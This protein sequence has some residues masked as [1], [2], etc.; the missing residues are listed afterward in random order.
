MD[1]DILVSVIILNY[2]GEKVIRKTVDS[3]IRSNFPK[4]KFEIIIV[5]NASK[6]KSLSII[7]KIK[8]KYKNFCI[9]TIYSSINLGFAGGN[10]LGI[11]IALGKYIALLNND[12]IVDKNWL[13]ELY[14]AAEK[15]EKVFAVG[16]K[17]NLYPRY[18]NLKLNRENIQY[19]KK[20][21]LTK[22]NLIT[23]TNDKSI[24]L[25]YFLKKD[26]EIEVPFDY[27]SD[28]YIELVIYYH[29]KIKNNL[30]RIINKSDQN[31]IISR[32]WKK[33]IVKIKLSENLKKNS[34]SKIQNFGNLIFQDGYGRDIGSIVRYHTQYYENDLNQYNKEVER[35][36]AC[37]AAVLYRK[38]VFKIIGLMNENYFMYYEDVDICEKARFYGFKTIYNPKAVVYHLHA[39]SSKEWS[40]FFIYHAEKGR[41]LN[42]F[43][44]FPFFIFIKEYLRFF[45]DAS[46]RLIFTSQSFKKLKTN[47]QYVK[48][49][50]FFF[51]S[52]LYLYKLRRRELKK[53]KKQVILNYEK[54]L[55]GYWL[56]Q[57]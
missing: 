54:I 35:Y 27:F 21:L 46:L 34:V 22:S 15:D 13:S 33:L 43:F 44:N 38:E 9:K 26:F 14:K 11:K 28:R 17:I 10:N 3:V 20:I 50:F 1:K 23:F 57:N 18:L 49:S 41:L 39:L 5:D 37:G 40:D 55:S 32:K 42:I 7:K 8:N 52:F 16:S 56:F 24:P 47:F 36:A 51:K 31:I 6:D 53:V 29:T 19:V 25:N 45:I 2:F 30:L 48:V 12:C 4:K